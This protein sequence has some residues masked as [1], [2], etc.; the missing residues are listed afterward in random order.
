[1]NNLV[2][3]NIAFLIGIFENTAKCI[4]LFIFLHHYITK[5]R[6]DNETTSDTIKTTVQLPQKRNVRKYYKIYIT[7]HKHS[8]LKR[9]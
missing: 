2:L 3:T 8:Y 9:K 1:M 7:L 4:K 6:C 5:Q